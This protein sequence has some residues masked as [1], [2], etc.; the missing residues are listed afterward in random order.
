MCIEVFIL[1]SHTV[2][3]SF[4]IDGQIIYSI[5]ILQQIMLYYEELAQMKI[6]CLKQEPNLGYEVWCRGDFSN[7]RPQPTVLSRTHMKLILTFIYVHIQG[8]PYI[9]ATRLQHEFNLICVQKRKP[10]RN[11]FYQWLLISLK[12]KHPQKSSKFHLQKL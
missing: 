1:P 10:H 7:T 6:F 12:K 3:I 5:E 4:S 2:L 11:Q 8:Q 9:F